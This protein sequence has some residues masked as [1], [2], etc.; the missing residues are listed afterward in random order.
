M[1]RAAGKCR[2]CM[3]EYANVYFKSSETQD[4]N[5]EGKTSGGKRLKAKHIFEWRRNFNYCA[6]GF[7]PR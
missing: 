4:V 2:I 1:T 3:Y 6:S 7:S 5:S